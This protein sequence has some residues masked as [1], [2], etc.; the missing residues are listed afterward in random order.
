L[1]STTSSAANQETYVITSVI[2]FIKSGKYYLN[3]TVYNSGA[4]NINIV[5]ATVLSLTSGT[6]VASNA[7]PLTNGIVGHGQT[8]MVNIQLTTTLSKGYLYT[9]VLTTA[10]GTQQTF[11]FKA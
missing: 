2:Y 11:T 7:T 6:V 10:Q 8:V 5:S 4:T 3:A 9:L 1:S